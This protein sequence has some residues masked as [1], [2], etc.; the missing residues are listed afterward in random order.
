MASFFLGNLALIALLPILGGAMLY[1][2]R[3]CRILRR[4]GY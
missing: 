1:I 3:T 4:R 2:E